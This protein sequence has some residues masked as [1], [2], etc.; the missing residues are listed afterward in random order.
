MYVGMNRIAIAGDIGNQRVP[1]V[2]GDEPVLSG[3]E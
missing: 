3:G 1:H 2:R